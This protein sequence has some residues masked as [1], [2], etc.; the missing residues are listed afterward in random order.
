MKINGFEVT[1]LS[2]GK[3]KF[4]GLEPMSKLD[5]FV[6]FSDLEMQRVRYETQRKTDEKFA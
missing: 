2:D 6:Y 5:A 4:E 1:E 3:L